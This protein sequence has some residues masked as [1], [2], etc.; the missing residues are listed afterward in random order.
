VYFSK[1]SSDELLVFK[2][3][4]SDKRFPVRVPHTAFLDPS[5]PPDA[6]PRVS[7]ESRCL[8]RWFD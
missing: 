6:E 8:L 5:C 2:Q 1:L 3:Y 4:D 7:I